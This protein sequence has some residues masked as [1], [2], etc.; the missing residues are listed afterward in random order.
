MS[1]SNSNS[2]SNSQGLTDPDDAMHRLL[3]AC[4]PVRVY[5]IPPLTSIRGYKAADWTGGGSGGE[6]SSDQKEPSRQPTSSMGGGE[7]FVARMRVV[8]TAT[9]V[10]QVKSEETRVKKENEG[11]GE[12]EGEEEEE[13]RQLSVDIRLEDPVS[14]D[15]FAAAPYTD[16]SA[17]EQTL[18]SSR[19][20]AIRVVGDDGGTTRKAILGIAFEDRNEA[21]DFGICLQEAR[22]ILNLNK[23][24]NQPGMRY[25]Q[26]NENPRTPAADRRSPVGRQGHISSRAQDQQ[27]LPPPPSLADY[28]L[29]PGEMIHLDLGHQQS[30][31]A[32]SQAPGPDLA[33]SDQTP[34]EAAAPPSFILPPPPP[35]SSTASRDQR[36][37]RCSSK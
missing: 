9:R 21:F 11:E 30:H 37:S 8:E 29:K 36:R 24:T 10:V 2:N 3:F 15:L 31:V 20:F 32:P 4:H 35:P 12:G 26:G 34:S 14:G 28:S 18:D 6:T 33:S 1:S 16:P 17:V 7:I 13:A 19:F 22:K 23:P 25:H 5:V 27:P